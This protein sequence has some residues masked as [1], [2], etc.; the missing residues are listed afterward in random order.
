MKDIRWKQRFQNFE[1]SFKLMESALQITNPDII[2]RAGIIQFFEMTLELAWNT[3]KDFLEEQGFIDVNSPRNAIKKAFEI[4]L[5]NDGHNWLK[6]LEDRNLMSHTY[7]EEI[8]I[9]IE[10]LIRNKYYPLLKMLSSTL[11]QRL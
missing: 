8:A 5:I 4:N 7:N 10:T 9:E 1:K 6:A 2:Q 11:K 3:L